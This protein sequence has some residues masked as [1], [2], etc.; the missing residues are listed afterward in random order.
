MASMPLGSQGFGMMDVTN[1]HIKAD[2]CGG[3]VT[4]RSFA[5]I[6]ISTDIEAIRVRDLRRSD[7]DLTSTRQYRCDRSV[8]CG[9]TE[10]AGFS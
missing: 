6:R 5:Y 8:C 2:A 7:P 3:P 1:L 9:V 4:I 10:L